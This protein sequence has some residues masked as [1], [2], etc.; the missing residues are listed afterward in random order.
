MYPEIEQAK[1]R[2]S[3]ITS[4]LNALY[5]EQDLVKKKIELLQEEEKLVDQVIKVRELDSKYSIIP[6]LCKGELK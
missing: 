3:M 5:Q 1:S 2:K 6:V 4:M